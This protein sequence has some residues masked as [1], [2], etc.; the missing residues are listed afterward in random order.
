[1]TFQG[2]KVNQEQLNNKVGVLVCNLGTPQSFNYWPVRKFLNQFLLDQ[3]VVELPKI[4]W[5]LILQ[6]VLFIRTFKTKK[7]YESIWTENGSPLMAY[8]KRLSRKVKYEKR[9][10]HRI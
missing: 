4:I 2:S 6:I 7:L 1:M 8:S 9:R 10:K 5:W 3:R